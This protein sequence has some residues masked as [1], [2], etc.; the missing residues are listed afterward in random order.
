MLS[1]FPG[2]SGNRDRRSQ[3]RLG[4]LTF[5]AGERCSIRATILRRVLRGVRRRLVAVS[6]RMERKVKSQRIRA[7]EFC[8]ETGMLRSSDSGYACRCT[9][10]HTW[11]LSSRRMSSVISLRASPRLARETGQTLEVPRKARCIPPRSANQAELDLGTAFV[12]HSR[13]RR[14]RVHMETPPPALP[15]HHS[16]V[17]RGIC[18]TA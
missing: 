8:G 17:G 11:W 7:G 1:R 6:S 14:D 4:P 10:G 16:P 5:G 15:R 18:E 13:F 9:G 3:G 12:A 2:P